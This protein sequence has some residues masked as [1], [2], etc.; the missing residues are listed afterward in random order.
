[1]RVMAIL[2]QLPWDN[3]CENGCEATFEPNLT[4]H[5]DCSGSDDR[6]IF[7]GEISLSRKG[8]AKVT[9]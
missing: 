8:A 5:V 4:N 9:G 7:I 6:F 1:M 2:R 3:T